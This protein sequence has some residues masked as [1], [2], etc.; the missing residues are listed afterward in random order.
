MYET[1]TSNGSGVKTAAMSIIAVLAILGCDDGPA[2]PENAAPV[3]SISASPQNVPAG[4]GNQTIV[5]LDASESTD[6]DGDTISFQWTVPNGTFENGTSA[7]DALIEVSF[8]GTAPYEVVLV[9]ADGNGGT[10]EAS[11]IIGLTGSSN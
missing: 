11:T 5:A 8:P 7:T 4:D 10:D 3:A 2:G 9:V 1:R 6:P